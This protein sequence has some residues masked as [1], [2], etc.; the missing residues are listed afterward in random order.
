MTDDNKEEKEVEVV[1][2]DTAFSSSICLLSNG[3]E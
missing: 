1:D 2:D 3:E